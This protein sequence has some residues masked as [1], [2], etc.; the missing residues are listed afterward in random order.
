MQRLAEW[1][2]IIEDAGLGRSVTTG[3]VTLRFR[4]GPGV[5]AELQRLVAAERD[6]CGFLGWNVVQAATEWRVE[7][8]GGD[9]ALHSLPLTL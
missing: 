3:M 1:R 7:I 9:E 4:V 2:R 6:C 8:S 5:G